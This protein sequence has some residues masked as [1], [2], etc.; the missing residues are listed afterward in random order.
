MP[1]MAL[2]L[3]A[4]PVRGQSNS[5]MPAASDSAQIVNRIKWLLRDSS[6]SSALS[7]ASIGIDSADPATVAVV[8]DT[9]VCTPG[10]NAI[11]T[12]FQVAPPTSA[13]YLFVRV[14][15]R[16]LA[17]DPGTSSGTLVFVLD[18]RLQYVKSVHGF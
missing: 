3:V 5:C 8:A 17:Y 1:G 14:G 11:T 7:R 2:L 15:P 12:R 13:Q 18:R 9:A 6:E 10:T 4:F 16:Y